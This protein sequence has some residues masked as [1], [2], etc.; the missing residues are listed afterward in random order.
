MVRSIA[1]RPWLIAALLLATPI[2]AAQASAGEVISVSGEVFVV[3]PGGQREPAMVGDELAAGATVITGGTGTA[4][5]QL[6][7]GRRLK[8]TPGSRIKLSKRQ[9]STAKKSVMLFF[10]RLWNKKP[11]TSPQSCSA[12]VGLAMHR[13]SPRR[14]PLVMTNGPCTACSNR[15]CRGV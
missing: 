13:G 10:G 8:L 6:G 2:G 4:E 15:W 3:P 11:S 5:L 12:A 7:A 1:G 9:R 14:L